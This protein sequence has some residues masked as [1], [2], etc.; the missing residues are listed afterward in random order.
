MRKKR[1][2]ANTTLGGLFMGLGVLTKGPVAYLS[3]PIFLIFAF[4]QT[5]LKRF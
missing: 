2:G 5:K 4:L 3:L 1:D